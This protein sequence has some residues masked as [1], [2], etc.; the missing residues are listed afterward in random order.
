VSRK[1]S[2]DYFEIRPTGH[3][4]PSWAIDMP[5]DQARAL[6][7]RFKQDAIFVVHENVLSV[8]G[9]EAGADVREI[10]Q[11][12]EDIPIWNGHGAPLSCRSGVAT[13]SRPT[14]R[15]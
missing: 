14:G 11:G 3:A 10:F 7:R 13:R 9:C 4:E 1:L 12:V 15:I 8:T 2:A 6:G 5:T